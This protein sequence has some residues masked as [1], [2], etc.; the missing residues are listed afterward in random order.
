MVVL[1]SMIF[2][3]PHLVLALL[4]CDNKSVI[5]L[6]EKYVFDKRT[7][8]I[9]IDCYVVCKKLQAGLTQLLPMSSPNQLADFFTK[10]LPVS[11]FQPLLSKLNLYNVYVPTCEGVPETSNRRG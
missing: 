2:S 9:E 8:H 4:F 10:A 1:S 3:V 11:A 6:A 7:K 5:H